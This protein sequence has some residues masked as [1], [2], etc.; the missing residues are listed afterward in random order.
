MKQWRKGIA[1]WSV[2]AR[3]YLSVPFTWQLKEAEDIARQWKG[4]VFAGG[5]AVKL[6]GAPWAETP[7][8]VPFDPLSFHNPLATFTT[9]GCPNKCTFCAVPKIEG[10]FR[11]LSAWKQAP[12]ICDNNILAS[13]KRHFK[14]VIDSLVPFKTCDFNQGLDVCLFVRWHADE[15]SRLNNPHIRFAWDNVRYET[16]VYD[17]IYICKEYG[18]RDISVYCLIGYKDTPDDAH[19]RLEKVR[20]WGAMPNPMRYQ[21]LDT[22]KKNSYV[23]PNWTSDE[24]KR[25]MRYY[26]RLNYFEHIPYKDYQPERTVQPNFFE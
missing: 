25:M 6:M 1:K 3:L 14:K 4:K 18:F 5:P 2:G 20:E 10:E 9:R 12:V 21:P 13:T 7:D 17:A 19:Y 11:E 15:L 8:E 23:A 22:T 24:L 26:S 16:Y